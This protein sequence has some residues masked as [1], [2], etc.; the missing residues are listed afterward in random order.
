MLCRKS[1][2]STIMITIP[3]QTWHDDWNRLHTIKCD[4]LFLFNWF[5]RHFLFSPSHFH[6]FSFR[7]QSSRSYYNLRLALFIFANIFR[8]FSSLLF[9]LPFS[10]F[11]L[12]LKQSL[13]YRFAK[14]SLNKRVHLTQILLP[15]SDHSLVKVRNRNANKI[16]YPIQISP[17]ISVFHLT[18]ESSSSQFNE[19][20]IHFLEVL[21]SVMMWVKWPHEFKIMRINVCANCVGVKYSN[22]VLI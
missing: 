16:E 5:G 18:C 14:S 10:Y 17:S 7:F 3:M 12:F 9:A 21:T 13:T 19:I 22:D 20:L 11:L 4:S 15:L 2:V 6:L 1:P 8:F